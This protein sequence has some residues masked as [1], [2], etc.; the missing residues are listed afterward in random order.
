[1]VPLDPKHTVRDL[2]QWLKLP[3]V[4]VARPSLGTINHSLLTV[5]ALRAAGVTVRGVVVNRYP[6]E[7]ASTAEETS[8]RAIERW[9]RVPVL[10]IVPDE[11]VSPGR[12]PPG[13]AA[14][15]DTVDWQTLA[16]KG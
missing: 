5:E 1:M 14:A 12:L 6:P 11:P 16:A 10:T 13:I 15:A 2:A 8:P 7:G 3:A 9:G 4:V